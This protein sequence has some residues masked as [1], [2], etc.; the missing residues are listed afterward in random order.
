LPL[1]FFVLANSIIS[2]SDDILSVWISLT[3][4]YDSLKS[5]SLSFPLR[6]SNLGSRLV[7]DEAEFYY[8]FR[9]LIMETGS[10]EYFSFGIFL[11]FFGGPSLCKSF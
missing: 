2:F 7:K 6:L 5:P 9:G 11:V 8:K 10:L 1:S 3:N 4:E